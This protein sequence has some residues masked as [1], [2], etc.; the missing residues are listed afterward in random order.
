MEINQ[1]LYVFRLM[2]INYDCDEK[3]ASYLWASHLFNDVSE[4]SV[5]INYGCD[6]K[7]DSY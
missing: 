7:S 6:S 5:F 1:F 4:G 3:S 2:S